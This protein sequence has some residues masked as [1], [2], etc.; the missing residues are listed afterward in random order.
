V[1][2]TKVSSCIP[3]PTKKTAGLKTTVVEDHVIHYCGC[4][5]RL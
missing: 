2:R 3:C 4:V 5:A 1:Q